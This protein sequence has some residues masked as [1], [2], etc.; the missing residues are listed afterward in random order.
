MTEPLAAVAQ[1]D[2][3]EVARQ[4]GGPAMLL[5]FVGWLSKQFWGWRKRRAV[6]LRLRAQDRK[7]VRYLLDAQRQTLEAFL[8]PR[9]G[10]DVDI[11]ELR[12]QHVLISEVREETWLADG[13]PPRPKDAEPAAT[14]AEVRE[15]LTRTQAIQVVLERDR[16]RTDRFQPEPETFTDGWR[17]G[18]N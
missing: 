7:D 6:E 8:G 18:G 12:R 4:W 2:P 15:L 3:W 13:H 11:E 17:G 10:R 9:A 1:P 5:A 14:Q 16:A